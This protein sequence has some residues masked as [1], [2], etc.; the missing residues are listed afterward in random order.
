MITN[1]GPQ[2]RYSVVGIFSPCQRLVVSHHSQRR[3]GLTQPEQKSHVTLKTSTRHCVL[4][5]AHSSSKSKHSWLPLSLQVVAMF[6]LHHSQ[7]SHPYF[8][9]S[10]LFHHFHSCNY[11]Q[12]CQSTCGWTRCRSGISPVIGATAFHVLVKTVPGFVCQ[13]WI[14]PVYL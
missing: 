2:F 10:S 6:L 14:S 3:L 11:S 1:S 8:F 13:F 7:T 4:H 12:W 9:F 5:A